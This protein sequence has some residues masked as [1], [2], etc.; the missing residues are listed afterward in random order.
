MA[1]A[2]AGTEGPDNILAVQIYAF[3]AILRPKEI[4]GGPKR[5]VYMRLTSESLTEL[6]FALLRFPRGEKK[7]HKNLD[8]FKTETSVPVSNG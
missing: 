4:G 6:L 1:L 7:P 8:V 2:M 5:M 3:M